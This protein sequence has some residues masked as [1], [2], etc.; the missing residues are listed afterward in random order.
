MAI[1]IKPSHKGRFTDYKKRTGMT[2]QQAPHSKNPH[3]RK[4]A[5]FARNASKWHHPS[6]LS[7]H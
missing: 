4:M 1:K 3:V 6:K 7:H 2:T 5:N